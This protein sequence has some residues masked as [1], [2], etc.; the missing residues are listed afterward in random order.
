MNI[1]SWEYDRTKL[2]FFQQ[3]MFDYVRFLGRHCE[4][5]VIAGRRNIS[6]F[7]PGICLGHVFHV[8]KNWETTRARVV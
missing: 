2:G 8:S 7:F 4:F 3:T 6:M 1:C 5:F